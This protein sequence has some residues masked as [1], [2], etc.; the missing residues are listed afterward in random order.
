MPK[1]K[2]VVKVG[3]KS[4]LQLRANTIYRAITV[5][6]MRDLVSTFSDIGI[7]I[8][9]AVNEH[10]Y[11]DMHS[12]LSELA[13]QEDRHVFFYCPDN[14]VVTTG[15]ADELA[16][17][18]YLNSHDLYRAI[19]LCGIEVNPDISI[20]R[21]QG[22]GFIG[23]EEDPFI[24]DFEPIEEVISATSQSA[25]ADIG[26]DLPTLSA[27]EQLIEDVLELSDDELGIEKKDIIENKVEDVP[28]SSPE[29]ESGDTN[30][31][32][33]PV[34]ETVEAKDNESKAEEIDADTPQLNDSEAETAEIAKID[35][36]ESR[37]VRIE[38]IP[39]DVIEQT[40]H[41]KEIAIALD[42][43]NTKIAEADKVIQGLEDRLKASETKSGE[44]NSKIEQLRIVI[45]SVKDERDAIQAEF[46]GLEKAPVIE[47]PATI[48]EYNRLREYSA[49]LETQLANSSNASKAEFDE[50][51]RKLKVVTAK[52]EEANT[53]KIELEDKNGQLEIDL[54]ETRQSLVVAQSDNTKELR[55][56]ELVGQ[57]SELSSELE[58]L[59]AELEQANNKSQQDANKI[60]DITSMLEAERKSKAVLNGFLVQAKQRIVQANDLNDQVAYLTS[61]KSDL[62]SKVA[63]LTAELIDSRNAERKL[64]EEGDTRV[65]LARSFARDELENAKNESIALKA[66]LD[67]V[68]SR[69]VAKETQYNS[70][71]RTAGIDEN[72]ALTVL[73]TN[74]T[75]E[76]VNTQLRTSLSEYKTAY[77]TARRETA[78]AKQAAEALKEQK[79]KLAMQ[80]K[81][82]ATGYSGGLSSGMIPNLNY[83][84][85]GQVISVFGSGS[86]GITTTAFS[87]AMKLSA[88]A[89]V[90]FIDFD[91]VSAKADTW[92]KVL[93]MID[94]VPGALPDVRKNTTLGLLMEFGIGFVVSR[95]SYLFRRV[96]PSKNGYCD[97]ASGLCTKVDAVKF[98]SADLSSFITMC[99]ND[100]D[101]VV[102][103]F[104]RLGTSD[105][106]NQLIKVFSDISFSS[107]VVTSADKIDIRNMRQ[108]I[109]TSNINM[110]NMAWLVNLAS[111][112]KLDDK[113][114]MRISPANFM[115]MPFVDDFYG[116]RKDFTK[117]RITK[118]KL[119]IFLDKAILKR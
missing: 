91:L 79:A 4:T 9:E 116:Q 41:Y 53:A 92:F 54:A 110:H 17:D 30:D 8:I 42:N 52:L 24:T 97:Y 63:E 61:T 2:I 105:V 7:I 74:K 117:D 43:A 66:K 37:L 65:E 102:I 11:N 98:V 76:T 5:S 86:Y 90:L 49:N 62:E 71:V 77:E 20:P 82:M 94:G 101:F 3:T 70:L 64:R 51:Q 60:I 23:D 26:Q 46:S 84:G 88:N 45:K 35:E 6:E 81:A 104:G 114:K 12:F 80:L 33:L 1:D 34:T 22:D 112:T 115:V 111:N 93:P 38:D 100:Y 99:G 40:E 18:I 58:A 59:K 44:L 73:E 48:E 57:V 16:L 103:D 56:N 47:D 85:R 21:N 55:I 28:E 107:V 83:S 87:I 39:L 10:E 118:D 14:D 25:V 72:G 75:L 50:L 89:R 19:H 78:E 108:E 29:P 109:S 106:G 119:G 96:I 31:A 36:P 15:L 113:T 67:L 27:K 68:T 95:K 69:L 13:A 32:N